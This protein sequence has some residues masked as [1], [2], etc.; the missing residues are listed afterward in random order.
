MHEGIKSNS[1]VNDVLSKIIDKLKNILTLYWELLEN[2]PLGV[3]IL[4]KSLR[5]IYFNK[6]FE[7]ITNFSKKD[8]LGKKITEIIKGEFDI[9]ACIDN[10]MKITFIK[11]DGSEGVAKV[12]CSALKDCGY[13]LTF[14]EIEERAKEKE[15]LYRDIVENA[16]DLMI[17]VSKNGRI[18]FINKAV[19]KLTGYRRE[20]VIGKKCDFFVHPEDIPTIKGIFEDVFVRKKSGTTPYYRIITKDGKIR[21]FYCKY[22]P[23]FKEKEVKALLG[24]ARDVT[25][26]AKIEEDLRKTCENI[27]LAYMKI[28]EAEELKRNIISNVS[29]ELKTP[30]TIMKG[31]LELALEEKSVREIKKLIR[32]SLKALN[33]EL[34]TIEKFITISKLLSMEFI[35]K[36]KVNIKLMIEDCLA[37]LQDRIFE[38]KITVEKSIEE[39]E[40]KGNEGYLKHAILNILDNAVKFN[41]EYGKIRIKVRDLGMFV[42]IVVEDTGIG[43]PR[44]KIDKVF[45]PMFQVDL[46]EKR[47]HGG[48]GLGLAIAREVVK[49]HDGRISISSAVEKGT[50]VVISLPKE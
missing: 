23:L 35:K 34:S 16:E 2:I 12:K 18:K 33:R 10:Y 42:E 13:Q 27:K 31:Y 28:K 21:T 48:L 3:V 25:E 15:D 45:E 19:E 39:L 20:E 8:L 26:K 41:R 9:E 37:E 50:R 7:D 17:I 40:I 11:K 32:Y 43:I 47:K 49:M 1:Q 38:K 22:M 44:D 14:F 46:S 4:D 36:D 29:H 6:S 24:I 30:I 5:I